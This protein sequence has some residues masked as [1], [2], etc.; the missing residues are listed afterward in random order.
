[1]GREM[2]DDSDEIETDSEGERS[3]LALLGS[4]HMG[5]VHHL[6]HAFS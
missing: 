1:M 5:T 3:P 6:P 2:Q 4:E